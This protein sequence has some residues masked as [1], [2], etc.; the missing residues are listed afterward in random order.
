MG[1]AIVGMHYTGMEAAGF[2]A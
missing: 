1:L 2:P